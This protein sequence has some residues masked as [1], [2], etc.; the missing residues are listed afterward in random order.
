MSNEK[1]IE[2]QDGAKCF[3]D[4][5]MFFLISCLLQAVG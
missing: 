4:G 3:Q 1:E 5:L 2:T